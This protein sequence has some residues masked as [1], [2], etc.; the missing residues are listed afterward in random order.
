[1][2]SYRTESGPFIPV[3]TLKYIFLKT[4]GLFSPDFDSP[5]TTKVITT[6]CFWSMVTNLSVGMVLEQLESYFEGGDP[7]LEYGEA[8]E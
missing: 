3:S 1:M 4:T 6:I 7:S 2:P 8:V 5:V